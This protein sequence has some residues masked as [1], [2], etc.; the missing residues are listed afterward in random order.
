MRRGGGGRG[1]G[2]RERIA[3]REMNGGRR[4]CAEGK[5]R[6]SDRRMERREAEV[7]LMK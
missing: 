6:E 2:E 7:M 3:R 1:Q 5:E 4:E